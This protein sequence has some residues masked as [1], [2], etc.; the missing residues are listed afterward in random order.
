MKAYFT[1][2]VLLLSFGFYSQNGVGN[3]PMHRYAERTMEKYN[4]YTGT[5]SSIRPFLKENFVDSILKKIDSNWVAVEPNKLDFSVLTDLEVGMDF[6]QTESALS[7]R[8]GAGV[9]LSFNLKNKL[10]I[11]ANYLYNYTDAPSFIDSSMSQLGVAP[12]FGRVTRIGDAFGYHQF[13]G[14]LH[15]KAGKFFALQVGNGKNFIGDG[16][17]S[18]LLSDVANN[19]PY[20][21][22]T[23]SFWNIKYVNLYTKQR[24]IYGVEDSP[25]K[26]R[27][28]YTATHY[29]DWSISK[30]VNLG[31]FESIVWQAKDTLLDR[32]FEFNYLNPIVFY[33][34]VEFQQGS[35]DN[36]LMGLNLSVNVGKKTKLYSQ[37]VLDEFLLAE[38]KADS[39]W[40]ANKYGVQ[41]G[42][43]SYDIIPG[44]DV[45]SEL[46]A[47]RPYTYSHGAE[48]QNYGH[49][50][51][52]LAHP[53]GSNYWEWVNFVSYRKS[54]WIFEEQFSVGLHGE[55]SIPSISYGGNIFQSYSNRPYNYG[56]TT[57]Q[58]AKTLVI[59]HHLRVSYLVSEKLNMRVEVGHVFRERKSGIAYESN[60]YLYVGLKT[61]LWNRYNDY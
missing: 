1:I 34:P 28:K 51:G 58:G 37:F 41:I 4:M 32:G 21:K 25:S 12:S 24:H 20:V 61:N 16:Y 46:S 29:L 10:N 11:E 22:L 7:Y 8:G 19:Y 13:Q 33:R 30:R 45:Q 55:D 44:L 39:G 5:N 40:W 14:S 38:I 59:F 43:K 27:G 18:L 26:F 6:N 42:V 2:F 49:D 15:Y 56:H 31:I 60:H 52:S 17:R 53:Y 36:A 47:V 50:N 23:T 3:I 48:V 9:G 57:V 54:K 35:A